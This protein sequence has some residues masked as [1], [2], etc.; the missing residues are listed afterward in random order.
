[1]TIE[2]DYK[3]DDAR[4]EQKT[5]AKAKSAKAKKR[6]SQTQLMLEAA[7]RNQTARKQGKPQTIEI[8]C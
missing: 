4:S 3:I 2:I 5:K 7:E 6:K 1:M 8:F